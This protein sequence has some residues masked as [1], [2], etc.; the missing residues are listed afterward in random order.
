LIWT[1]NTIYGLVGTCV[2]VLN[3]SIDGLTLA[4]FAVDSLMASEQGADLL[5]HSNISTTS[6]QAPFKVDAVGNLYGAS[7]VGSY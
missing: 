4:S 6:K 3:N 1:Y 2:K 5:G 7:A